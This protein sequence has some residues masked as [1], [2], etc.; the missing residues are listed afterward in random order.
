MLLS[1]LSRQLSPIEA[2]IVHDTD[3]AHLLTDS[4]TLS[5]PSS[6]LFFALRT[7]SGDGH[8]YIRDLYDRGVRCFVISRTEEDWSQTMPDANY[9][10]VADPLNALQQA[11]GLKRMQYDIPVIGIT[12]SNGKTIVKEFLYQLLRKDYRIVRSPRSYNS[13]IGVPL[14]IWQMSGEHTLGIFEAG[15][16][17]TNEMERLEAVIRPTLGIITNIGA[18]HQ[19]N[20]AD[21][22]TKLQEKL[23]LFSRCQ[24]I[25]YNADHKE[26][27]T[28]ISSSPEAAVAIGWSKTNPGAQVYIC[29]IETEETHTTIKF[30]SDGADYSITVPFTDEASIE[31]VL[32]C[33]TLISILR[34]EVLYAQDRF[35]SL[36][37]VEM[38]MEVKAGDRGN[39]IINDVY[40][41]DVYSLA[42]ALDFQQRRTAGTQMK[43]VVVLSDILQSGMS[44][45]EL[46]AHVAAQLR[47]YRPD[48]FIGIGEDIVAQR[49]RFADLHAAFFRDV[50]ELLTSAVLYE[51]SDSCILLKGARKYRFE[52]ITERL[53]QQVHETA[54]RINLSAIVHNLNYYRSLVPSG[55]KT[56]CMVKAQGYGVGSYELVKTLQEHRVDYIAVAVADEGKELRERGITM[57][58]VVMNPERNAFQMLI[59]Y[60]LEPEIYSFTLLRSFSEIVVRNGLSD[61]PVHI[62]ID[63]GMHRLGFMPADIAKL[64]EALAEY[65][66]LHVRSVFTHLA[67][68]DD[69]AFDDFTRSQ[70]LSFDEVFDALAST[71]GYRPL[72]HTLNTAGVERFAHFPTDMIRL[73]IG[74]YGVTA[75]GVSGLRPVA[76]LTTTI[77]QI[78]DVP[79]GET[80]GYG[81]RGRLSRDSRIAVMP[82]GYADGLDRRLSCGV[83]EVVIRGR[84]CP[85]VGN[86]CMDICMAD[87][88]DIAAEEG[89][90]V[91]LFG[92]ELPIAEVAEKMQTIAYEVLTGI[93]PRVRRVYFQE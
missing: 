22:R 12:G 32:H 58:I 63:T 40:S 31:D 5:E 13:Q 42:L 14:S 44:A 48:F 37:P 76:T 77:L 71:L 68:A 35:A 66:G 17:Q 91:L 29:K 1:Y 81:R 64:T 53:V 73:G 20:F 89:D 4:R 34:P 59:D 16:S 9:I 6:T 38:R 72:R 51:C 43:K 52:Q 45:E 93:S 28:A 10:R 83:G 78:K 65:E 90:T 55:T 2:R 7:A 3:L 19:E 8:L 30:R 27:A 50:T 23:R 15:I 18:A 75:S 11:A 80:V 61:Y 41:S 88:T 85:I 25:V 33:I 79:A 70:L 46:Y 69:P 47:I 86:V 49:H 57:P 21:T 67:A 74:L 82:I 54:L 36:E 84:R 24:A 39:T 87:I 26:I 62:K 92:E 60:R 56:I